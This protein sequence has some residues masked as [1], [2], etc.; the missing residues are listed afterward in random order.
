MTTKQ[1]G[2]ACPAC[3]EVMCAEYALIGE[4]PRWAC[5]ACGAS[6]VLT[7]TF[8]GRAAKPA[9]APAPMKRHWTDRR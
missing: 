7:G 3:R 2:A 6:G 1:A 9:P 4:A 8:T 5:H